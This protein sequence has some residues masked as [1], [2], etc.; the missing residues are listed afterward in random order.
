MK[1]S[2]PLAIV[3]MERGI[4]GEVAALWFLVCY[5]YPQYYSLAI[6]AGGLGDV[7]N[8]GKVNKGKNPLLSKL[9]QHPPRSRTILRKGG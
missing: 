9:L 8:C 3:F 6:V 5:L 1:N 2:F 4:W 7:D